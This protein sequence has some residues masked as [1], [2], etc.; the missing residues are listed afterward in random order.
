MVDLYNTLS[1]KKTPEVLTG[2][3]N[4]YVDVRDL[5]RAHVLAIQRDDAGG[6]R[7]IVSA[8]SHFWQEV[9][10]CTPLSQLALSVVELSLGNYTV[11]VA[12]A[13]DSKLP[14]KGQAGATKGKDYVIQYD[15]SRMKRVLGFQCR[16]ME[17]TL[18][19]SITYFNGL[20]GAALY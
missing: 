9:G 3:G 16:S 2:P 14:F 15:T 8:G 19:D 11:D 13:V 12:N 18:K 7:I 10:T 1:G 5:A 6:Q 4:A 17:D 20:D